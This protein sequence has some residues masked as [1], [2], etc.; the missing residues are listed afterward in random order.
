LVAGEIGD[1]K[2]TAE[3]LKKSKLVFKGDRYTARRGNGPTVTDT[4]KLDPAQHPKI[5]DI[6]DSDAPYKGETLLGIYAVK[7]DELTEC[8]APPG[9]AR[10]A[11]FATDNETGQ[12]LHIWKH[13]KK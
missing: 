1:R 6:T 12:F 9:K 13:V 11:K 3:E 7:G 5:I 8:F 10:P 4:L 2:M